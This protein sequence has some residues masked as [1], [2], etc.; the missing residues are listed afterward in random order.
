MTYAPTARAIVTF[1][2]GPGMSMR[3]AAVG[4][5]EGDIYLVTT[6]YASTYLASYRAHA[7]PVYNIQWNNFIPTVFLSCAAEW[8]V[9]IW[10]M[11]YS[12]VRGHVTHVRHVTHVTHHHLRPAPLHLRRG[13]AGGRRVLGALL[14]H[15]LRRGDAGREGA[16]VRHDVGPV[17]AH[18]RPGRRHD[19]ITRDT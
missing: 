5:D 17:Q 18:L 15:H 7:T 9:K 6:E 2:V 3:L 8:T 19:V 16:R 4:T 10:D 14:Q 11:N 13:C 12:K 1:I